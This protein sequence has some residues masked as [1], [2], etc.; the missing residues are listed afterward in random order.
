MQRDRQRWQVKSRVRRESRTI[1]LLGDEPE[2]GALYSCW[3]CGMTCNDARDALG[4]ANSGSGAVYQ[5][6]IT[7]APGVEPGVFGSNL[8][9]MG[10]MLNVMVALP[11]DASG[12]PKLLPHSYFL[13]GTGCPMCH[14]LNWRGDF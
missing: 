2:G 12:N 14:S 13:T 11:A 5:D 6:S 10:G 1:K 3:Y 4:D 9:V 8:A 7:P